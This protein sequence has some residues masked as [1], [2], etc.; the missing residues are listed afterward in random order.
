[1][2]AGGADLREFYEHSYERG[3]QTAPL[4]H[5]RD[6]MYGQ[7]IA[8]LRPY[9]RDGVRAL[10]LGC[11]DGALSLYMA[12]RGC[13]VLGIDLAENAVGTARRSAE[14]HAVAGTEFRRLDFLEEWRDEAAFDLILCSHVIEHVPDDEAFLRKIAFALAPGGTLVLLTPTVRSL[15]YSW[16]RWQGKPLPFDREVGHLRRYDRAGLTALA[17]RAGLTVE[18]VRFLDSPLREMTI[19]P[20][21]LRKLQVILS[22]PGIRSFFNSLDRMVARLCFPATICIHARRAR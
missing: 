17:A 21:P 22:L 20:T 3:T 13:R 16:H 10:D 8:E 19:I 7:V 14:H 2:S 4:L 15:L 1:M 6:F 5:D 12:R 9:L 11:N 18:R